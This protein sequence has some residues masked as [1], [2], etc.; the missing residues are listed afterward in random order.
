MRCS[1]RWTCLQT[2]LMYGV[3]WLIMMLKSRSFATRRLCLWLNLSIDLNPS[4]LVSLLPKPVEARNPVEA[5]RP[6][7]G[8]P[9]QR[10]GRAASS[11]H[12]DSQPPVQ[13]R[14]EQQASCSHSGHLEMRPGLP[15]SVQDEIECSLPTWLCSLYLGKWVPSAGIFLQTPKHDHWSLISEKLLKFG[16]EFPNLSNF[17]DQ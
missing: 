9:M 17:A 5:K 3:M 15:G 1:L 10:R 11:V 4:Q 12:P 16:K 6:K 7:R 8:K 14:S 13:E 2:S